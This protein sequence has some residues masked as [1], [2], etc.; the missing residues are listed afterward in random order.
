M[1]TVEFG[2]D[3]VGPGVDNEEFCM[4]IAKFGMG[5]DILHDTIGFGMDN[6]GFTMDIDGY[7]VETNGFNI[8]K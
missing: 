7:S 8:N 2:M 6:G 5:T 1:I 3:T 4:D